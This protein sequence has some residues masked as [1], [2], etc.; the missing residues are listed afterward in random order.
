MGLHRYYTGLFD[1][2]KTTVEHRA[3][4]L[5]Q[6]FI[7][8]FMVAFKDGKRVTLGT[9][10]FTVLPGFDDNIIDD[11]VATEGVVVEGAIKFRI[12]VGDFKG[13][14]PTEVLD[15]YL[16]IGNVMPIRNTATG[17]TSYYMGD[18]NNFEEAEDFMK[19]IEQEGIMGPYVV[20]DFNGNIISEQAA[21]D[22]LNQ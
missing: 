16:T 21:Q 10:G 9:S 13:T 14:I 1:S 19:S 3:K 6:G 20:G 11:T 7:G 8:A 18:F 4:M 12:N 15:V 22:L 5:E 17:V 2:K